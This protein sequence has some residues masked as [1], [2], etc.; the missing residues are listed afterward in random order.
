MTCL[1]I[2]TST[3]LIRVG[4]LVGQL[5]NL[6]HLNLTLL[7]DAGPAVPLHEAIRRCRFQGADLI[8]LP[9]VNHAC[10]DECLAAYG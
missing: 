4:A 6:Y 2:L 10:G 1:Q 8:K 5:G 3:L 7:V 9:N